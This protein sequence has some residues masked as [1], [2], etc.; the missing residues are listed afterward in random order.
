MRVANVDEKVMEAVDA[1]IKK[2]PDVSGD[3]LFGMAKSINSSIGKLSRR[4]FHARYPLQIKRNMKLGKRAGGAAKK[5]A[6]S[7]K[8]SAASSPKSAVSGPKS[9]AA[10]K[11]AMAGPKSA[12]SAPKSGKD[13]VR[14][15]LLSFATA[16]AAAETRKDAVFVVSSVDRYVDDVMKATSSDA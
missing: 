15:V 12:D 7:R 3:E 4:Q 14:G 6:T 5:K 9:G 8:P 13:G 10:R 16:L 1:A 2:N 11:S